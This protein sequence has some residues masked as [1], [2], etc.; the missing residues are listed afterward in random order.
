MAKASLTTQTAKLFIVIRKNK[1]IPLNKIEAYCREYGNEYAFICHKCDID[2]ITGAVIP[3]HYHI[4]M[5]A[6]EKRQRLS[7]H[8]ENISSFFG[9]KDNNG[10]EI[11]KYRSYESALQYLIHKNDSQKTQHNISEIH[12][13]IDK[14]ELTTLI[15]LDTF[16]MSFELV[17]STCLHANNIVDVIRSLGLSN[18]QRYRA[19]IWD[20]LGYIKE[21]KERVDI[22]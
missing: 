5:N 9:F 22:K 8:L 19:T 7:T 10:I 13:N 1:E 14:D 2:P 15:S 17:Y 16:T 21:E 20:I 11:D 12:T 3:V 6:K 4:V 18:Y